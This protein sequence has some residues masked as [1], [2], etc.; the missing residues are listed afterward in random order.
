MVL[1]EKIAGIVGLE[2]VMFATANPMP[3]DA[4]WRCWQ[5]VCAARL[6]TDQYVK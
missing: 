5:A 4:Q 2:L 1:G 3:L 6:R